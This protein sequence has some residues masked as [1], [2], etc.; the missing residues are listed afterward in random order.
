MLFLWGVVPVAGILSQASPTI[1]VL[2]TVA[3]RGKSV[4]ITV[5]LSLTL[6]LLSFDSSINKMKTNTHNNGIEI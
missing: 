3:H 1:L 6:V 4:K 2:S 5:T